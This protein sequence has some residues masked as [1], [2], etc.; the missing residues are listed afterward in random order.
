MTTDELLFRLY[1]GDRLVATTEDWYVL[2]NRVDVEGLTRISLI[3]I[4]HLLKNR[5]IDRKKDI[6]DAGLLHIGKPTKAQLNKVEVKEIVKIIEDACEYTDHSSPLW[7]WSGW[8]TA[9]HQ[10][11]KALKG[12]LSTSEPPKEEGL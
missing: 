11:L 12:I 6:T 9:H 10:T 2:V 1:L 8:R 7:Y 4:N 5:F 3:D